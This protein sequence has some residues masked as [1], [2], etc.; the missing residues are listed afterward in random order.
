MTRANL[1]ALAL[2][3][4]AVVASVFAG[5]SALR[6]GRELKTLVARVTVAE[7]AR[8]ARSDSVADA[9]DNSSLARDIAA[10]R[11][12]VAALSRSP[13]PGATDGDTKAAEEAK[14]QKAWTE[15]SVRAISETIEARLGLS[16]DQKRLVADIMTAQFAALS[17]VNHPG[18]SREDLKA[19]IA[20]V[21]AETADLIRAVLTEGQQAGFRELVKGPAGVFGM[22]LIP[23]AGRLPGEEGSSSR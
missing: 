18:I 17:G 5:V 11:S 4:F 6:S 22:E 8:H 3:A 20:R 23:N 16:A 14:L 21:Q 1:I 10:L 7:S 2:A 19:H 13:E 15:R 9:P 12:K